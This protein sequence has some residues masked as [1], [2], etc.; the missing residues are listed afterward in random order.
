MTPGTLTEGSHYACLR[1]CSAEQRVALYQRKL[2]IAVSTVAEVCCFCG[3]TTTN[4]V[5]VSTEHCRH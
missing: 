2:A 5:V 1:C 3:V 4:C